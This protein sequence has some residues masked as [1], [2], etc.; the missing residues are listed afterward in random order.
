[1]KISDGAKTA[2]A[3][4]AGG[5]FWGVEEAFK[6]VP[7]VIG[8]RVGYIGG[9]TSNPDYRSVCRGDTGHAEAC[10]VTFDSERVSYQQLLE[11]FWNIHDPTQLNRQ[12]YDVGSQYRSGIFYHD[13]EQ[14]AMAERSLKIIQSRYSRPVV[15]SVE[16]ATR[17]WEAEDYHQGYLA[18]RPGGYCHVDMGKVD[19]II[20]RMKER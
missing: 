2:V 8:T 11:I 13:P 12:G 10:E 7:G 18:E 6:R 9:N 19:S 15:T 4:F 14:K 16:P 17:F 3:T 5:C 20:R 1:M